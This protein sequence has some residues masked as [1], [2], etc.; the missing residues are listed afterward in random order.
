MTAP[1]CQGEIFL[2]LDGPVRLCHNGVIRLCRAKRAAKTPRRLQT[3]SNEK[4]YQ[5]PF[6]K[7]Y[8]LL[9]AKAL[10][11]GRTQQEVDQVIE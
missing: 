7:L 1:A 5:M 4:I 8:P 6:A 9:T 3:M 2:R 10:R 11:K